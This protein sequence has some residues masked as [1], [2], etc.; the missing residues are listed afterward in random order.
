MLRHPAP[1]RRIRP[2]RALAWII[3]A[4]PIAATAADEA[5]APSRIVPASGLLFYVESDGL[6][7]HARAWEDTEAAAILR[8]RSTGAMIA[9]V[10]RQVL[11]RLLRLV[12]G[13]A[14]T[15][16]DLVALHEH[17]AR[18]GFAL[19]CHDER[20]RTATAIVLNDARGGEVPGRLER[21]LRFMTPMDPG[22]RAPTPGRVR[23]REV[24]RLGLADP[25][26][27]AAAAGRPVGVNDLLAG[28]A[29]MPRTPATWWL[30]GPS[31]ILVV[32]PSFDLGEMLA[33]PRETARDIAARH[34][35]RVAAILATIEREEA[36]ATTHPAYAL[37]AAEGRDITGFEAVGRFFAVS[38]G[39][40]GVLAGLRD[41]LRG[42]AGRAGGQGDEFSLVDALGLQRATKIVGRWGFRGQA[43]LTDVRFLT[44]GSPAG[45]VGLIDPKGLDKGHLPPIPREMG[46]FAVGS[47][48]RGD[49]R[50]ALEPMLGLV[51]PEHAGPLE[52]MEQIWREALGPEL[53]EELLRHLGPTWSVYASPGG[54]D[55]RSGPTVPTVLAG[56]TDAS[57]FAGALDRAASR[58]N[59]DFRE[60]AEGGD[61][62][63]LALERLPA[64]ARGYRLTSPAG[65][66]AWL[67]DAIRPTILVGK[68]SVAIAASPALARRAIDAED[69]P[70][71]AW[72]PTGDLAAVYEALPARVGFLRVGNLRD[73][74]WP[75]AIAHLPDAAGPFLS[76]FVG[77]DL[78]D[79]DDAAPPAGLLGRLGL[80]RRR[81]FRVQVDRGRVPTPDEV[82]AHIFPSLLAATVDDRGV[83]VI[84]L[85]ALPWGCLGLGA[86]YG[87]GPGA[88]RPL[89][90]E[91]NFAPA[92]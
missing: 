76:S 46:A 62:P 23:G 51:R 77:A 32:G 12:P 41:G 55:G 27:E 24:H 2:V 30:E 11:D 85:E 22:A 83:R 18:H 79:N 73:S 70:A 89:S 10:S 65:S 59:E 36:D 54:P 80:S 29:T 16:D 5:R 44:P 21:L 34:R 88:G 43:I 28:G 6:D 84:D 15:G 56:A 82:R 20:G 33:K 1:R 66:A 57:S 91:I 69:H 64:P 78:G 25:D 47:F 81:G 61:P 92:R 13:Q 58:I 42:S 49:V 39:D 17:I 60:L 3:A 50:G 53:R 35:A 19:A 7:A 4:L 52:A 40:G 63:A 90:I 75:E 8:Q 14:V 71:D 26:A 74:S 37:A 72:K 68:S 67:T 87:D 86:K 38:R 45:L 9:D 48:R 31:L